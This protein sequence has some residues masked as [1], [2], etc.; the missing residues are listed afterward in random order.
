MWS[1]VKFRLRALFHRDA[2]ES[3]LDAELRAHFE[4]Q[5]EKYVSAGAPREEALR[6][7]RLEFGGMDQVKEDCRDARGVSLLENFLQDARFAARMLRKNLGFTCIAVI[8]LALGIG[9]NAAIFSALN[10]V[11]LRPLP[12]KDADRLVFVVTLREGFDPFG[13]SLIE[14]EAFRDRAHSL[15]SLG[16]SAQ[17]SFN[18]VERGE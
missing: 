1:D 6:R 2:L 8:T 10:T 16:I 13:S 9:A 15:A 11:L 17:R 14:Y 3:E 4:R 7:A 12:V 5:V 18:L